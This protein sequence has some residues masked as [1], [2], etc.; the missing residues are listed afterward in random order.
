MPWGSSAWAND[1]AWGPTGDPKVAASWFPLLKLQ[2]AAL[3]DLLANWDAVAPA[4]STD[5]DAVRR[6]IGTVGVSSPLSAVKKT[7]SAIRDSEDVAEEIDLADFVEAYQ[8]VL[9]DL[10]DAENDLYSANFADFSGG[11]QLK[12]T[13]F[14][15]AAKKSIAAAKLNFEE[16]LRTLQLD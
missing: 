10:S 13:N 15:K 11:G 6:K 7:F 4:G 5:G 1:A 12:G 9:T 16:I 8:A 2:Y 3:K 14:I